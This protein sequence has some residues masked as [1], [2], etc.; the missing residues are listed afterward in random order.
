VRWNRDHR[1]SDVVDRRGQR[2][3]RSSA[4]AVGLVRL[5]MPLARSKFGWS[6]VL[7]LLVGVGLLQFMGGTGTVAPPSPSP[8]G[9]GHDAASAFVG[10]VLDDVQATYERQFAER[11]ARY[12]RA[13]LVLF[14]DRTSTGGCGYGEAAT[15]PF[16]CPADRQVYIDLSFF[17]QLKALGAP[18]DFAQ[19]YVIAHEIGHHV[20]NLLG[21][22][23]RVARMSKQQRTGAGGGSVRLELMADCLAGAW[24]HETRERQLLEAGDI[25]ESLTAAAA[26]GDDKLQREATGVVRPETF[27]HGTSAQRARW[28]RAGFESGSMDACDTF[29]A[30]R[31]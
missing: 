5:L 6:G 9:A 29:S 2:A 18:G 20:Q 4:G 15:G 17:Q 10:F 1:S 26:I 11:N 3:G 28:F 7:V 16:Y 22:T 21:L 23:D 14:T 31:L 12:E 19:A 25:E 30:A 27:S 8:A 24:A 13:K